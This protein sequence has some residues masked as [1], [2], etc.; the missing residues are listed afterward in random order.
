MYGDEDVIWTGPVLKACTLDPGG[1]ITLNFEP[2]WMETPR[3]GLR[4]L[5]FSPTRPGFTNTSTEYG[6]VL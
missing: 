2:D 6:D 4:F 3:G 1:E 5:L